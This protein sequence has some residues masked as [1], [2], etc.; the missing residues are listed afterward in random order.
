MRLRHAPARSSGGPYSG[1]SEEETGVAQARMPRRSSPSNGKPR[2]DAPC[3]PSTRSHTRHRARPRCKANACFACIIAQAFRFGEIGYEALWRLDC[4]QAF[5][6]VPSMRRRTLPC[7]LWVGSG[8]HRSTGQHP[9]TLLT[10][11][12]IRTRRARVPRTSSY[13]MP[14]RCRRN[15]AG[16]RQQPTTCPAQQR[17]KLGE[18]TASALPAPHLLP[19]SGGP[20]MRGRVPTRGLALASWTPKSGVHNATTAA[21]NCCSSSRVQLSQLRVS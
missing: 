12:Q 8:S 3:M 16:K 7:R 10:T 21:H 13:R 1:F 17:R 9:A 14:A 20:S 2:S 5:R 15:R 18:L 4:R 11:V 19:R 6:R